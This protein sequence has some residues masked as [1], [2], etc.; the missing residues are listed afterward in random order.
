MFDLTREIKIDSNWQKEYKILRAFIY[1]FFLVGIIYISYT[2]LFPVRSFD[3]FFRTVGALKN[4]I[5]S[6]RDQEGSLITEG[7]L[8]KESE[9]FFD[10]ALTGT[11][12]KAV[13][14]I[15]LEDDSSPIE[16]GTFSTRKSFQSLFYPVGEPLGFKEG[17]LIK[18]NENYFIISDGKL[19]EFY[20]LTT[21][22]DMGYDETAFV[23]VFS[24]ELKFNA[25]GSIVSN[26]NTYPS[27]T[28]FRIAEEYYQLQGEKLHKFVSE[29]AFLT[30]YNSKQ[31]IEKDSEFLKSF[32]IAEDFIGFADGTLL[33]Q[34]LSGFIV[35]Q[36]KIMPI[37]DFSTFESMGFTGSDI[38][39]AS[40]EEIGIYEK[41]KLF[42]INHPHPDGTILS[43]KN[44]GKFHY[45]SNGTR[46]ELV[47]PNIIKSYLKKSPIIV[48]E[49]ALET[50][51]QCNVKKRLS[52]SKKYGCQISIEKMNAILGNDYQFIFKNDSDTRIKKMNITFKKSIRWQNLKLSLSEIKNKIITNYYG[53]K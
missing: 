3:F 27:G 31:F 26:S 53:D 34:G 17:S 10:T 9:L 22:K 51:E 36:G 5:I 8:T 33:S 40:G 12:S 1:L 42:T 45:I 11:F 48:E 20:S 21:A 15:I 32:T 18:N 14:N 24:E 7:N 6:P 35:S 25:T 30:Q 13:I 23:E 52:F 44:I 28:L 47:G 29:Q 37:D 41:T 16:N 4:T 46:R 43:D 2:M 38:I 49:S 50:I 39:A 19:R